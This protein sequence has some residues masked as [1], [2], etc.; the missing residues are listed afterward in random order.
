MQEGEGRLLNSPQEYLDTL[1]DPGRA[2]LGEFI[3]HM[4]VRHP[5]IAPVM[6]RQRPMYKVGES[7]LLF[8]VSK[9]HFC[10]HTL[11]FNL[12]E[13]L[14]TRLASAAY[15]KGCV[16]VRF[17]D[18]AAK[19]LLREL[20]E[21]VVR[22]SRQ[23]GAPKPGVGAAR[24]YEESLQLAFAGNK[25]KWRSLYEQLRDMAR[26]QLPQFT[27]YF[28]AV[29]VLWKHTSTFAQ[30]SAVTSALRVEFY[31]DRLYPEI[32]AMKTVQTSANR[33]AHTVECANDSALERIV[34]YISRSYQLTKK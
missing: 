5:D 34:G 16:K 1:D 10:V 3:A 31:L 17:A 19:P 32:A 24:S 12:L 20:C 23:P 14:K 25:A 22:L 9:E 2:W 6:F 30:V 7:Y 4:A 8:T 33:V 13:G 27:E 29:N 11:H 18:E 15:G 26:A 28:P 21:E